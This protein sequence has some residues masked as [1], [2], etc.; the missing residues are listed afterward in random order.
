MG[1]EVVCAAIQRYISFMKQS[2]SG[3]S[4]SVFFLLAACCF[5]FG[6]V[7]AQESGGG[8]SPALVEYR[9]KIY[10]AYYAS[11]MDVWKTAIDEMEAAKK[12]NVAYL[13]DLLNYQYGY[14][15]WCIGEE[16]TAE[17]ERY[18]ARAEENLGLLRE[19]A[20]PSSTLLAYQ[21]ALTGFRIGLSPISAP[22]IGPGAVEA[23]KASLEADN[24]N[25]FAH[26]QYGNVLFYMPGL[27]GGSREKALFHYQTA[28]TLME[29][30]PQDTVENWNYLS[31]LVTI[32]R[33]HEEMGNQAAAKRVYLKILGIEPGFLWVKEELLPALEERMR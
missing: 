9:R 3:K 15:G 2:L 18:L 16:R 24:E 29:R 5:P 20:A 21:A 23:A 13:L 28:A 11:S 27:F 8:A 26:L 17:A 32:A 19:R 14:I 33:A 10:T 22:F 4:V 7:D 1:A 6:A 12:K 31:V 25:P 30:R